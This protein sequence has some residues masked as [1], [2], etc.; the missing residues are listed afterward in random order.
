MYIFGSLLE[1][2]KA[3]ATPKSISFR[4]LIQNFRRASPPLSYAKSPP[5]CISLLV[6]IYNLEFAV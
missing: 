5:G 2:K 6:L 4:S 1:V 3:W